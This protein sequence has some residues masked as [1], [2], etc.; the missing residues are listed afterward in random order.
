MPSSSQADLERQ[1]FGAAATQSV[2]DAA[3]NWWANPT[4]TN[5]GDLLPT[6]FVMQSHNR[7]QRM[8]P[9]ANYVT[10]R[11]Y[12]MLCWTPKPLVLSS[13]AQLCAG[14]VSFAGLTD[15]WFEV[16]DI[17][18]VIL[19]K[20][21][22][23]GATGWNNG[24]TKQ[25]NLNAPLSIAPSTF[26]YLATVPL[27]ATTAGTILGINSGN[28]NHGALPPIMAGQS[29][30]VVATYASAAVGNTRGALTNNPFQP[31]FLAA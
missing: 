7:N 13:I 18:R 9:L 16:W 4:I 6:G 29:A 26:F 10:G 30:D 3:K 23:N 20:T 11:P 19:Q 22:N 12:A 31:Y 17:N 15:L 24:T 5:I 25:L 28:G 27:F 1:F 14:G 2:A 21:V 8:D